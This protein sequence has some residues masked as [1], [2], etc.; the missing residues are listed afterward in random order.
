MNQEELTQEELLRRI[1]ER[2]A[3]AHLG[4]TIQPSGSRVVMAEDSRIEQSPQRDHGPPQPPKPPRP[5]VVQSTGD[6]E[7]RP[8]RRSQQQ[9]PHQSRRSNPMG[10]QSRPLPSRKHSHLSP[11]DEKPPS[12]AEI[13]RQRRQEINELID[14]L[15][16]EQEG[17]VLSRWTLYK[18][19]ERFTMVF[20][21]LFLFNSV[22]TTTQCV[23]WLQGIATDRSNVFGY[24]LGF[25]A[26]LIMTVGQFVNAEDVDGENKAAYNAFLYPDVLFTAVW[27]SVFLFRIFSFVLLLGQRVPAESPADMARVLALGWSHSWTTYILL[28]ISGVLATTLSIALGVKSAKFPEQAFAGKSW[29]DDLR[30]QIRET[31]DMD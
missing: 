14:P 11:E 17:G 28:F 4:N 2:R 31:L 20:A 1:E 8:S 25:I 18:N 16:A 26:S 23:Y 22:M 10:V 19:R 30:D 5:P 27:W 21:T 24:I 13:R 3:A 12:R 9:P 15:A 6:P 29:S 7:E